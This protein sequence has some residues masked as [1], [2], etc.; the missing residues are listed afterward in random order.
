[1]NQ[2]RGLLRSVG[3]CE[4]LAFKMLREFDAAEKVERGV[5]VVDDAGAA[6][7]EEA[8]AVAGG[9]IVGLHYL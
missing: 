1:M 8:M 6:A 4:D 3:I 7:E 2:A 5:L 9:K